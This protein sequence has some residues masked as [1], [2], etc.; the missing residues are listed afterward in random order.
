MLLVQAVHYAS[1][2]P[3]RTHPRKICMYYLQSVNNTQW[4]PAI[5]LALHNN[6]YCDHI[7]DT[8]NQQFTLDHVPS[9]HTGCSG[10]IF[11]MLNT[12]R[13]YCSSLGLDLP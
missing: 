3:P 5:M 9:S 10:V 13:Q 2:Q 12:T 4:A 7:T 11:I 6:V 1:H 8:L